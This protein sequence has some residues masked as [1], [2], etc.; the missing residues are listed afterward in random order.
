[1]N[2]VVDI[3]DQDAEPLDEGLEGARARLRALGRASA[4]GLI[5]LDVVEALALKTARAAADEDAIDKAGGLTA[6]AAARDLSLAYAKVSRSIRQSVMLEDKLETAL[7]DR[8][9]GLEDA[10]RAR[11]LKRAEAEAARV[12]ADEAAEFQS[13]HG[14]RL[15]REAAVSETMQQISFSQREDPEEAEALDIEVA[16]LLEE[17]ADYEAYGDRPVSETVA[18]LCK[19]LDLSADWEDFTREDWAKEEARAGVAGSP[20][21]SIERG[22]SGECVLA[23]RGLQGAG[24]ASV[25]RQGT[26]P[27]P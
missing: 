25:E 16:E 24:L 4:V 26:G 3:T 10:R 14:A 8:V 5:L 2:A 18:R 22:G 12:A 9:S 17:G 13:V 7:R 1:M 11:A 6:V 21:V 20:F 27:P 15:A 19:A 23:V